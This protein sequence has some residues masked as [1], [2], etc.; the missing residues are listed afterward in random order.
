MEAIDKLSNLQLEI[1]KVFSFELSEDEIKDIRAM[2]AAYF[3]ERVSSDMDAL[4]EANDWGAQKIEEW[5]AEHMRTA[6]KP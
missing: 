3:A 6:Y 1:L 4:F 5:S 2:L